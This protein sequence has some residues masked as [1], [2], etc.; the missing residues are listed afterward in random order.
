MRETPFNPLLTIELQAH[1]SA[2]TELC[3]TKYQYRRYAEIAKANG[4]LLEIHEAGDHDGS[5]GLSGVMAMSSVD[6]ATDPH[7]GFSEHGYISLASRISVTEVRSANRPEL[8]LAQV[9]LLRL[10]E[11]TL[12]HEIAHKIWNFPLASF[13]LAR[14]GD[15]RYDRY[16]HKVRHINEVLADR[17]AWARVF[18][19]KALPVRKDLSFAERRQIDLDLEGLQLGLGSLKLRLRAP[20]PAGQYRSVST[21]MLKEGGTAAWIGPSA[22]L[23]SPSECEDH[24]VTPARLRELTKGE[25]AGR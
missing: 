25:R 17:F 3:L 20:L 22:L 4:C 8:D 15:E 24:L 11:F 2:P 14:P 16:Y 1:L 9:P 18:P 12:W 5:W 23:I 7:T 10:Y 19:G 13:F 6:D 21:R